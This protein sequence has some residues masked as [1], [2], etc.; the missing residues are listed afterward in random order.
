MQAMFLSGMKKP[1]FQQFFLFVK[2]KVVSLTGE[3]T[4]GRD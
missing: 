4:S 3:V 2:T 1:A